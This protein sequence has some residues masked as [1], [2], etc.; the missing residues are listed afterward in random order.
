MK[1]TT[2]KCN[3]QLK[4]SET[5]LFSN[6]KVPVNTHFVQSNL[7]QSQR[8]KAGAKSKEVV[9]NPEGIKATLDRPENGISLEEHLRKKKVFSNDDY[10]YINYFGT[11]N[12]K[13]GGS[14]CHA[15]ENEMLLNNAE[16][17]RESDMESLSPTSLNSQNARAANAGKYFTISSNAGHRFR[18]IIKKYV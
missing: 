15:T 17:N 4:F 2:T 1:T 6:M 8:V 18:K 16:L 13:S 14:A 12:V 7:R 5:D 11:P 10:A 9:L 3:L